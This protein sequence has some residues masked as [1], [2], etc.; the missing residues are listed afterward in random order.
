MKPDP[1]AVEPVLSWRPP[2]NLKEMQRFLGFANYYGDFIQDFSAR[3]N[4]LKQLTRRS[5]EYK[6]SD[7]CQK[8]FD[9]LKKLLTSGPVLKLADSTGRFFLD[10]DASAVAIAAVLSQR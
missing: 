9:E 6:W 7:E 8:T 3:A 1:E 4:P 5:V 2:R 10:T